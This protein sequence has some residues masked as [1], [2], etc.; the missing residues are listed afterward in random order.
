LHNTESRS[1]RPGP[2][3]SADQSGRRGNS[4]Y[5]IVQGGWA[6]G[7]GGLALAAVEGPG[8]WGLTTMRERALAEAWELYPES[9]PAK[10]FRIKTGAEVK[11]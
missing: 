2:Y 10:G 1:A 4:E 8:R 9:T 11:R 6:H 3:A 5:G 7:S